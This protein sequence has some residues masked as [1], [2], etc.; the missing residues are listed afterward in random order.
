MVTV[1]KLEQK[2]SRAYACFI[3]SY[4]KASWCMVCT[5]TLRH[6]ETKCKGQKKKSKIKRKFLCKKNKENPLT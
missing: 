2:H 6:S 3:E 1:T 4:E 5:V